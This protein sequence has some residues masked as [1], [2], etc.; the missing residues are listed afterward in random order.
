[1]LLTMLLLCTPH[2]F[3]SYHHS[4]LYSN[5]SLAVLC[6]VFCLG[7]LSRFGPNLLG[8]TEPSRPYRLHFSLFCCSLL[9]MLA[10]LS[11]FF[12]F[13]SVYANSFALVFFIVLVVSFLLIDVVAQLNAAFSFDLHYR[14]FYLLHV[15]V[16]FY[17]V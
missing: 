15:L 2:L 3:S 11:C 12:W 7:V 13:L 4:C 9:C 10:S 1:M 8:M 6:Y 14:L 5:S 16:L 17:L